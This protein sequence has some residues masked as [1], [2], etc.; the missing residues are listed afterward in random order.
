MS[1][2]GGVVAANRPLDGATAR[3]IAGLF[4]EVVVAPSADEEARAVLAAKADLRL[5]LTGASAD[6][7]ENG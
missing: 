5:L 7:S 2:F 3:A 4:T 6:V 1:A